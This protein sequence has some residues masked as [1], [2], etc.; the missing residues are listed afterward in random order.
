MLE[1]EVVVASLRHWPRTVQAVMAAVAMAV[2]MVGL[3]VALQ[4]L[5]IKAVAVAVLVLVEEVLVQMAVLALLLLLHPQR[6]FLQQGHLQSPQ[7][8]EIP[9]TP[10]TLL[11][12]LHS[13]E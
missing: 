1:A 6:Q 10:S 11:V 4:E 8:V 12:Q 5:P 13:K 3:Q 7:V 9:S 2:D